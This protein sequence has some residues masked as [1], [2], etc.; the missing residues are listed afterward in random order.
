MPKKPSKAKKQPKTF[1]YKVPKKAKGKTIKSGDKPSARNQ[2]GE[3]KS[4][5]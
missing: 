2:F 1:K 3:I 5:P 4:K